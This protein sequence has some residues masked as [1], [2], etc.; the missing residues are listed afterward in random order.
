VGQTIPSVT[1][2][3]RVNLSTDWMRRDK[4]LA[5]WLFDD[6]CSTNDPAVQLCFRSFP[7]IVPL[8]MSFVRK[9]FF[10]RLEDDLW[11]T[12]ISSRRNRWTQRCRCV[13]FCRHEPEELMQCGEFIRIIQIIMSN[14]IV[15][16]FPGNVDSSL[17]SQLSLKTYTRTCCEQKRTLPNSMRPVLFL[18]LLHSVER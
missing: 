7:L 11:T 15:R 1:L 14:A 16:I 9:R 17:T 18:L 4:V 6:E 10:A 8:P 3:I 5:T 2:T 12:Q 13:V